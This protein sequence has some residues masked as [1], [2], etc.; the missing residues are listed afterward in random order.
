MDF[1]SVL[2]CVWML[3]RSSYE[4]VFFFR[5]L[6][7]MLDKND[8]RMLSRPNTFALIYEKIRQKAKAQ[9]LCKKLSELFDFFR[10]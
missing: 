6:V 4:F 8:M 5:S 9:K 2:L 10:Q 7:D 1:T 3:A